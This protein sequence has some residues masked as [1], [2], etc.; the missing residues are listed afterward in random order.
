[1]LG[2]WLIRNIAHQNVV[3]IMSRNANLPWSGGYDAGTVVNMLVV[4]MVVVVMVMETVEVAEELHLH[5]LIFF[6]DHIKRLPYVHHIHNFFLYVNLLVYI[7]LIRTLT[8]T[9]SSFFMTI[10]IFLTIFY[11][12][13]ISFARYD[14]VLLLLFFLKKSKFSIS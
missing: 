14:D 3:M 9:F 6:S 13:Y 7:L 11:T 5:G 1:M 4:I 8:L 2:T 10:L 12:T